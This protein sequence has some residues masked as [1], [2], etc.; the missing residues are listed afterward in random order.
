ML[1]I[2]EHNEC[3]ACATFFLSICFSCILLLPS[4]IT[5]ESLIQLC[6]LLYAWNVLIGHIFL[7]EFHEFTFFI[8]PALFKIYVGLTIIGYITCCR[9][10]NYLG[11][12]E[13]VFIS[14]I[15]VKKIEMLYGILLLLYV[16]RILLLCWLFNKCMICYINLP[17]LGRNYVEY[18]IIIIKFFIYLKKTFFI[19]INMFNIMIFFWNVFFFGIIG[20]FNDWFLISKNMQSVFFW[21]I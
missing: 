1:S 8:P 10:I 13:I 11:W 5:K 6:L 19:C 4:E 12:L 9:W 7:I 14:L 17:L 20:Y 2:N 15:I 18:S 3:D 21:F 16:V